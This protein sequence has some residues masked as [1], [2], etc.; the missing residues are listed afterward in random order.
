MQKPKHFTVLLLYPDYV[1]SDFGHETYLAF[2]VAVTII[3]AIEKAQALCARLNEGSR[4]EDFYPLLVL[5]G[6]H[7][8]LLEYSTYRYPEAVNA[9]TGLGGKSGK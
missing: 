8:D 4:A 5:R 3:E 7:C 1:A 9:V 6:H 2:E